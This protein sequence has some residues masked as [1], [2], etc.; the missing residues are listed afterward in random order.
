MVELGVVQAKTMSQR[1]APE[2]DYTASV[3]AHYAGAK[4][5][6]LEK[7]PIAMASEKPYEG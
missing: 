1:Q 7:M 3:V 5:I 6:V 2:W 4:G